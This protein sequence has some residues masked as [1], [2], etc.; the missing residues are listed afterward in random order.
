MTEQIYGIEAKDILKIKTLMDKYAIN[1][2]DDV[3]SCFSA[4]K[5]A[6]LYRYK[7]IKERIRIDKELYKT[8]I[9]KYQCINCGHQHINEA[10]LFEDG[11][12]KCNKCKYWWSA[13]DIGRFIF[14]KV[15]E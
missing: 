6:E 12:Y 11:Q 13:Q 3:V 14:V 2:I 8:K 1:N 10:I 9:D 4:K 15:E 7:L 5:F